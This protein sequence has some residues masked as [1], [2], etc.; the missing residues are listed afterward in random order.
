[1]TEA[2]V[3]LVTAG[4]EEEGVRI[5]DVL[6]SEHLAACVNM[7]TGVRSSF[8]W[9][10]KNQT[11]TECLLICKTTRDA[12]DRLIARVKELHSYT[13]PEV[14]ALQVAAGFPAYLAWV[15]DSIRRQ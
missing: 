5:S 8:F 7:I 13:V 12:L 10:G 15:S 3:I 2:F 4:S 6:V 11:A 1:M 14:I 9:E